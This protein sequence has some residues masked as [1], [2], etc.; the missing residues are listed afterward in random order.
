MP[1][2]RLRQRGGR[3]Q[4]PVSGVLS[5]LRP[6]SHS[7]K[8]SHEDLEPYRH[9]WGTWL[10]IDPGLQGTGYA[11]WRGTDC[12]RAGVL[13]VPNTHAWWK[14]AHMMSRS[15]QDVRLDPECVYVEHMAYFGGAKALGWR[16]G[17]LQRT[18]Y[19]EGCIAGMW[20]LSI[21]VPVTVRD[22]KGQL[23][24]DVVIRRVKDRFGAER[25]ARLGLTEH[26]WD[27]VGMGLWVLKA[28]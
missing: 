27:A 9:A 11:V 17:D 20:D 28:L 26:A 21:T 3:A 24:K 25:C 10:T 18:V 14:R 22:W 8:P 2:P 7:T 12:I 16:S 13:T 6:A 23:P 4:L 5:G 15:V 19:L 1:L